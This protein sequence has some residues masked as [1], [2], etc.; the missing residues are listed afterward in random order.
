M[1]D[2]NYMSPSS[3]KPKN[4]W[5]PEGFLGGWKYADD[6]Y[7]Y[8][9]MLKQQMELQRM[10]VEGRRMDLDQKREDLPL[11]A[12]ERQL[13]MA[14][15][16]AELPLAGEVVREG[17]LDI[18][19]DKRFY[20]EVTKGPKAREA[21]LRAL[22]DKLG[23]ADLK[24][25][26]QGLDLTR[27][28]AFEAYQMSKD[29]NVG[30]LGALDMVRQ[31]AEQYKKMGFDIPDEMLS[32]QKWKPIAD[33]LANNIKHLQ[34]L[35]IERAKTERAL[36]VADKRGQFGIQIQDLRNRRPTGPG[37][38]EL[39]DADIF[40]AMAKGPQ[41]AISGFGTLAIQYR[42]MAEDEE[43]E[44]KAQALTRK[45]EMYEKGQKRAAAILWENTP[46]GQMF[47]MSLRNVKDPE[48]RKKILM[49]AAQSQ[50]EFIQRQMTPGQPQGEV[51]PPPRGATPGFNPNPQGG[52]GAATG[53]DWRSVL[54]R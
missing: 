32:P 27:N 3:I 12:L 52:G 30:E 14:K 8:Q 26:T 4:G 54:G 45:A 21:A 33:S 5:Q 25:Y 49:R 41:A 22:T 19:N 10:G 38:R 9:Q 28:L 40:K 42:N 2:I 43:D 46:A 16:E 13:R 29:P 23:D 6:E 47:A 51:T 53:R 34:Q 11:K 15:G 50:D 39:T 1:T 31:R 48:E 35:A 20:R 24:H 18:I 36:E 44:A 17:Q 37:R 7:D